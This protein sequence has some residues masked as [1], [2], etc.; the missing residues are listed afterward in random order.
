MAM[1]SPPLP[2]LAWALA[3]PLLLATTATATTSHTPP[4]LVMILA[5][6]E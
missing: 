3:L 1:G 4:N 5:D 2:A 6:G